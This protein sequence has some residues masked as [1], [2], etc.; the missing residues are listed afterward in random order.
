VEGDDVSKFTTA[1]SAGKPANPYP[2]IRLFAHAARRWDQNNSG[3]IYY[4]NSGNVPQDALNQCLR[5]RYVLY[6]GQVS[7]DPVDD[8]TVADYRASFIVPTV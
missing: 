6:S 3:N 1:G 8:A 7:A 5:S 4:L 2:D